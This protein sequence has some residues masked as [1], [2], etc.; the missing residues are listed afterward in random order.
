VFAQ[1]IEQDEGECTV[2][3]QME[4]R[5]FCSFYI[6]NVAEGC[7]RKPGFVIY[8]STLSV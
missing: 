6:C 8:L 7:S 2:L 3:D 5:E 4:G 1:T